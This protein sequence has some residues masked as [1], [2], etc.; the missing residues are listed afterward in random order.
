MSKFV[1]LM[2]LA[3]LASSAN[4]IA[5]V[6][7]FGFC[8]LSCVWLFM[9]INGEGERFTRAKKPVV[10]ALIVFAVLCLLPSQRTVYA[11]LVA[12]TGREALDSQLGAKAAATLNGILDKINK[13]VTKE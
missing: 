2:W 13:E 8:M 3:D 12:E 10:V 5:C 6:M 11:Y 1:L 7:L 9:V 4:T